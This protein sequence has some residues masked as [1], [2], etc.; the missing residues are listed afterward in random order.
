M[1]NNFSARAA[2]PLCLIV[3]VSLASATVLTLLQRPQHTW[4][5]QCSNLARK[6]S[7]ALRE[8]VSA[9]LFKPSI[10]EQE[11]EQPAILLSALQQLREPPQV[12]MI[13]MTTRRH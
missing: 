5:V 7:E 10:W 11:Q 1:S 8:L 6:M 2:A 9:D 12:G 4:H 13:F 3:A